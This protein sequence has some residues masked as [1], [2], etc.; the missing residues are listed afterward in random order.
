MTLAKNPD[1]GAAVDEPVEKERD[2][3]GSLPGPDASLQAIH[4][5]AVARAIVGRFIVGPP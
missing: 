2:T 4:R 3:P 5:S 1:V